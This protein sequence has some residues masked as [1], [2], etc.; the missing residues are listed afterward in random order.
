MFIFLQNDFGQGHKLYYIIIFLT[1]IP[2]VVTT[3]QLYAYQGW[4][5]HR[6]MTDGGAGLVK[7]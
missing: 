5:C 1:V 4:C 6:S 2:G 7:I 3:G